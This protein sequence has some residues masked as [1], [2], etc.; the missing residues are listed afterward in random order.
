M[1][2][3]GSLYCA[4]KCNAQYAF[5]RIAVPVLWKEVTDPENKFL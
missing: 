2:V 5:G 1:M 4:K 3:P